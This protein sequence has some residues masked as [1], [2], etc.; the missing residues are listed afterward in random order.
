MQN[1]NIKN[2]LSFCYEADDLKNWIGIE[3]W[4][5]LVCFFFIIYMQ[6]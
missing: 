5:K 4:V 1:I 2:I 3:A 6:N